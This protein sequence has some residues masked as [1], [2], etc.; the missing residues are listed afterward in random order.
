MR[1]LFTFLFFSNIQTT[2]TNVWTVIADKNPNSSKFRV[3]P[4]FRRLLT[5]NTGEKTC[6]KPFQRQEPT[7]CFNQNHLWL[8]FL[9]DHRETSGW[10]AAGSLSADV[11]LQCVDGSGSTCVCVWSSV[12]TRAALVTSHY[13]SEWTCRV[14]EPSVLYQPEQSKSRDDLKSTDHVKFG[15]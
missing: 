9:A 2:K 7:L 6:R 13:V 8:R 5:P 12:Q 14:E 1:R 11:Y 3:P 4:S 15:F 10:T